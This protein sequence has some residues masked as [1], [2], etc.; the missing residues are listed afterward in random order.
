MLEKNSKGYFLLVEEGL[1]DKSHH[2]GKVAFALEEFKQLD[3]A[4]QVTDV[5]LFVAYNFYLYRYIYVFFA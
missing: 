2:L 1:I 5:A 3:L 4:V